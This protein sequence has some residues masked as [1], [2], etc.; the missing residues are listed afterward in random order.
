VALGVELLSNP[1][2]LVFDEPTSG[3]DSHNSLV[4][5]Q[6]LSKLAKEESKI[7]VATIHQPSTLMFKQMDKL[8]LLKRGETIYDGSAQQIIPYM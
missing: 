2:I 6:L 3:L 8:Y 5:A 4:I 1:K 7:I